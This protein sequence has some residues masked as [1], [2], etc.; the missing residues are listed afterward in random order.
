MFIRVYD[1]IYV[2][3]RFDHSELQKF[4][5]EQEKWIKTR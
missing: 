5:N 4:I 1:V 2:E 3:I